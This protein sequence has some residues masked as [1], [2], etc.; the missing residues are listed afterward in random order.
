MAAQSLPAQA[1]IQPTFQHPTPLYLV[2]PHLTESQRISTLY[3][4][5]LPA[6]HSVM[7]IRTLH[8]PSYFPHLVT[9]GTSF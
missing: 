2:S 8:T 9:Y 7:H 1:Y 6:H 4:L 3:S 5:S